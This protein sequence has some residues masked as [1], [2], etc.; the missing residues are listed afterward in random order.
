MDNRNQEKPQNIDTTIELIDVDTY[1]KPY[2]SADQIRQILSDITFDLI[3]IPVQC[4]RSVLNEDSS[5]KGY[6]TVGRVKSYD[7]V[8]K[9][10]VIE[11]FGKFYDQINTIETLVVFPR[12]SKMQDA[13]HIAN[14]IIGPIESFEYVTRAQVK[15]S[16]SDRNNRNYNNNRGRRW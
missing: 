3:E 16:Q 13:T 9:S 15:P 12:T 2:D 11:I 4:A 7:A 14:L 6:T 10:F 8:A 5:L 1:K